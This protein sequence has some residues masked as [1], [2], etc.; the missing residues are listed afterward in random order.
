[1]D[2]ITPGLGDIWMKTAGCKAKGCDKTNGTKRYIVISPSYEGFTVTEGYLE[3]KRFYEKSKTSNK[4]PGVNETHFSVYT[5]H[6]YHSKNQEKDMWDM[7]KN[8]ELQGTY[9]Y[10]RNITLAKRYGQ[11]SPST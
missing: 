8:I 5:F 4:K 10:S 3:P 2:A 7:V 1:M 11:S 9:F 6:S